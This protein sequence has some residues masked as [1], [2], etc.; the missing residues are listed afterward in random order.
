MDDTCSEEF[1]TTKSLLVTSRM[2]CHTLMSY[3]VLGPSAG[4][5]GLDCDCDSV[6]KL[7]SPSLISSST[8]IYLELDDTMSHRWKSKS[9]GATLLS[10][11]L[12]QATSSYQYLKSS[13]IL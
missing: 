4:L 11:R 8:N 3:Y 13:Q 5:K 1:H 12:A 7:S 9:N 10:V 2:G 6:S